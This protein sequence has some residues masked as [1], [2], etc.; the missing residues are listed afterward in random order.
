MIFITILYV[1]ECETQRY[2]APKYVENPE[3]L[4]KSL[5][6]PLL[7]HGKKMIKM[8]EKIINI[9]WNICRQLLLLF[10]LSHVQLLGTPWTIAC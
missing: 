9:I 3:Q 7:S 5:F 1:K 10:G 2:R 6:I 4:L 8:R